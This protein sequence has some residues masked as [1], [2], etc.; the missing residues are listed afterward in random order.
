ME[1]RSLRDLFAEMPEGATGEPAELLRAAGFGDVPQPLL[2][3]AITSYAGTAPLEVAEHLSP[4]AVAHGP[5]PDADSAASAGLDD[6]F[7]LLRSAP[8]VDEHHP[9]VPDADPAAHLDTGAPHD[10]L[11]HGAADDP[12]DLD[13]L[14]HADPAALD[15][16]PDH[17][18]PGLHPD[19]AGEGLTDFGAGHVEAHGLPV[20]HHAVLDDG[21]P[22]DH[23]PGV[24]LPGQ[25]GADP[26]Y[27]DDEPTGL[28][29]GHVDAMHGDDHV[30]PAHHHV[31]PDPETHL[32]P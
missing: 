29:D 28:E 1:A 13:G 14:L 19:A 32:H 9:E 7:D 6:G 2:A 16:T 27:L 20:E 23:D 17:H 25:L 31:G 4:F 18:T 11:H 26:Q 3:E 10:V 21:L 8:A 12:G 30:D 5:L 22:L 15:A 24:G